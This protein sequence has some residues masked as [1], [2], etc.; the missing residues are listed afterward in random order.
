[1]KQS[2]GDNF[3]ADFSLTSELQSEQHSFE[4][5]LDSKYKQLVYRDQ[6]LKLL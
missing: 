4:D 5:L 3:H 1:M 6:P 2:E